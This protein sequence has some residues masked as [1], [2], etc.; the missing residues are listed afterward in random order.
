MFWNYIIIATAIAHIPTY[1]PS[2]CPPTP[3]TPTHYFFCVDFI[4]FVIFFGAILPYS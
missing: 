4:I 2:I 3:P 1:N